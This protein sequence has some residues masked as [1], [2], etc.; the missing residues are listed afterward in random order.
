M[1]NPRLASFVA[2]F[3]F[4]SSVTATAANVAPVDPGSGTGGIGITSVTSSIDDVLRNW[5]N[6]PREWSACKASVD[7]TLVHVPCH[8]N[9]AISKA[10]KE[11]AQKLIELPDVQK[12]ICINLCKDP[13]GVFQKEICLHRCR[14]DDPHP[15]SACSDYPPNNSAL[16]VHGQCV[17][18]LATAR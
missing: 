7:C 3:L 1:L 2:I 11:E 15:T 12:E 14:E 4:A 8:T 6:I 18:V 5:A 16:C 10:H 9:F 17:T 13:T